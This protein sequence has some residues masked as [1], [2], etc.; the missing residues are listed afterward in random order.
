VLGG[1]QIEE[2]PG[3]VGLFA[4]EVPQGPVVDAGRLSG[5]GDDAQAGAVYQAFLRPLDQAAVTTRSTK[6][7]GWRRTLARRKTRSI[8][9]A[10]WPTPRAWAR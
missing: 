7:K 9:Q 2:H 8:W 10:S 1:A 3:H 4:Q 6:R 5:D